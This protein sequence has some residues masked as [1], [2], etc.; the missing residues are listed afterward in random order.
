MKMRQLIR[1]NKGF[2]LIELLVVIAIIAILA[3]LL[4]PA[5]SH[6]KQQAQAVKCMSGTRQ[7]LLGWKMYADDNRDYLAPNDYPWTTAYAGNPALS[8]PNGPHLSDSAYRSWVVG[9]M[10]VA[11]DE[12][13]DWELVWFGTLP[14]SSTGAITGTCLAPYEPNRLIWRCPADNFLDARQATPRPH[15]RSYSM[16]SAVGTLWWSTFPG[17]GSAAPIGTAVD[18]GW[19]LGASYSGGQTTYLTYGKSTSFT[20]PG[21]ANTWVIM[22]ENPWTINDAS[23][24]I[25]AYAATGAN[26]LIDFPSG[27]HGGDC[28]IGFSDA[29]AEMHKWKD[30]RTYNPKTLGV[31][32]GVTG[33]SGG[34]SINMSSK[35]GDDQ[36]LFWLALKTSAHR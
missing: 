12:N 24:A 3:S 13:A 25:S 15:C 20:S 21:A 4:L 29:H 5:L 27:N 18:G 23:L 28:G 19:L 14:G 36:D 9:S 17:N 6:D 35:G 8:G 30:Y 31:S 1:P 34:G 33:G 22:D 26:Y 16:N 10:A 11:Q 2:T 32:Q 7:L